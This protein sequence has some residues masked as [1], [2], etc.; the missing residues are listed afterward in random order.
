M[1]DEVGRCSVFTSSFIVPRSSL[2]QCIRMIQRAKSPI[3]RRERSDRLVQMLFAKIR[4][5]R[6]TD[7]QLSVADLPE[8][9]VADAHLAGGADEQ[10]RIGHA[11]GVEVFGDRL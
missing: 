7:I 11:G 4:P 9:I 5:E 6:V 3:P 1:N 2:S 8:E 10:I